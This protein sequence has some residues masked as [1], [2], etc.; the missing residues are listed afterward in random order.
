MLPVSLDLP[1]FIAPSGFS[2][3]YFE[4]NNISYLPV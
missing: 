2:N 1:F 4:A 3:A